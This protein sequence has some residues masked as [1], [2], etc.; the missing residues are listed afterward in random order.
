MNTLDDLTLVRQ[1]T[2]SHNK[3]AFDQLVVRYQSPIRRFFLS[4]TLGDEP[5][6]DDLAQ[7]TFVKAYTKLAQY[8][9]QSKFSTWLYRIAYNVFY[10]YTRQRKMTEGLDSPAVAA[11][12]AMVGDSQLKMDLYD[13]L[14]VLTPTER[15]C[16]TLQLMEGQPIDKIADITGL[17]EGTVKSHLF[18][19]KGKLTTYLKQNGYDGK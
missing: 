14:D 8:R 17:A 18:R 3:R 5:L 6:S 11:R 7:D 4:Q 1:V 15:L 2:V 19:G 16:V 10:D 9:G 12:H 13:A